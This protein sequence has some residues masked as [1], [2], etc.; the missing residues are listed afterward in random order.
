MLS[1]CW[2][3]FLH[4]AG[5]LILNHLNGVEGGCLWRPGHQMQH[6]ITLLIGQIALIQPGGVFGHCPVEKQNIFT[7]SATQMGWG[8][9]VECCGSYAG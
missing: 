3:L 1:T 2:M 7:V 9:P 5:Q 8:I 4:T 6:S